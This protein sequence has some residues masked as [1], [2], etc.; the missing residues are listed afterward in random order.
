MQT[1]VT[2]QCKLPLINLIY[3][4]YQ[5]KFTLYGLQEVNTVK[6]SDKKERPRIENI[7]YIA[8]Y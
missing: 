3:K 4:R 1:S 8:G 5:V 2:N 7:S 6:L